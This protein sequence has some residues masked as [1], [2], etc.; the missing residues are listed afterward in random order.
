MIKEYVLKKWEMEAQRADS[1]RI[2]ALEDLERQRHEEAELA[3][4]KAKQASL[5]MAIT[6]KLGPGAIPFSGSL[7][8]DSG[9]VKGPKSSFQ[10]ELY[11]MEVV[12]NILRQVITGTQPYVTVRGTVSSSLLGSRVTVLACATC[13]AVSCSD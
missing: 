11:E 1:E 7:S 10:L 6:P 8:K 12:N 4:V 5:L 9:I 3:C 13:R 2:E